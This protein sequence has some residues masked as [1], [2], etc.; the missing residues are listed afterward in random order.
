MRLEFQG[1][2]PAVTIAEGECIW[3]PA[4]TVTRGIALPLDGTPCAFLSVTAAK[5][6]T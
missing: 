3:L 4:G 2:R 5:E 1:G 6:S